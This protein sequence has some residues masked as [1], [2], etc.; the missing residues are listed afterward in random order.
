MRLPTMMLW[1]ILALTKFVLPWKWLF[2]FEHYMVRLTLSFKYLSIVKSITMKCFIPIKI[3]FTWWYLVFVNEICTCILVIM[4]KNDIMASFKN[5]QELIRFLCNHPHGT[6]NLSLSGEVKI[7]TRGGRC[8]DYYSYLLELLPEKKS[9]SSTSWWYWHLC[10]PVTL[11]LG[12][13][14]ANSNFDED[15][16]RPGHWYKRLGI[17]TWRL[18]RQRSTGPCP[19]RMWHRVVPFREG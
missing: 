8:P 18:V 15:V 14:A 3:H 9:H 13:E 4:L 16:Q 7:P 19:L 11:L 1:L 17:E 6:P 2:R 5:K 10:S 12:T